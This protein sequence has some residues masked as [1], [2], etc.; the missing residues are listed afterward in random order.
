MNNPKIVRTPAGTILP[1][2]NLKGKDYL[3]VAYR[4]VWFREVCP[5]GSI[6]TEIIQ[7]LAEFA[8][9]RA[10]VKNKEGRIIATAHKSQGK[11]NFHDFVE[12]AET[13]AIGRALALCGFGTQFAEDLEEGE[14]DLSEDEGEKLSDAPLDPKP[15]DID[16]LRAIRAQLASAMQRS[17]LDAES[18]RSFCELQFKK[19]DSRT[20]TESE[21][22][23]TID[24]L[25]R[26]APKI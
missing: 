25:N 2:L 5:E 26:M 10:T 3:N 11:K 19:S 20:L 8:I 22:T 6:E 14:E 4:I 13:G 24:W 12:K 18:V 15:K 23:K 17:G 1:I 7:N 9:V 21:L 16:P